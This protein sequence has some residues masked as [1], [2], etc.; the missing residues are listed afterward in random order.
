MIRGMA[1]AMVLITDLDRQSGNG[2]ES[3][4]LTEK[5]LIHKTKCNSAHEILASR[6][7]SLGHHTRGNGLH[8]HSLAI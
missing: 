8:G 4:N 1:N 6:M 5:M 3:T 7:M 2:K